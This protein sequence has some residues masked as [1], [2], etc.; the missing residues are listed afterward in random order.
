MTW[1]YL[2]AASHVL[3]KWYEFF[4]PEYLKWCARSCMIDYLPPTPH[5]LPDLSLILLQCSTRLQIIF[6]LACLHI[7]YQSENIG[8]KNECFL[9][10]TGTNLLL[11]SIPSH[12][13]NSSP[14][15]CSLYGL[16]LQPHTHLLK[17]PYP[18]IALC[19]EQSGQQDYNKLGKNSWKKSSLIWYCSFAADFILCILTHLTEEHL[20]P[21]PGFTLILFKNILVLYQ[22]IQWYSSQTGLTCIPLDTVIFCLNEF[23][24]ITYR[25]GWLCSKLPIS[26]YTPYKRYF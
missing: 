2:V 17:V 25:I 9:I 18:D 20:L 12:L 10:W 24:I 26:I 8:S 22:L 3:T 21:F 11:K 23:K 19:G 6:L 15:Y 7:I 13:H 14:C 1:Q 16:S 5:I 4:P